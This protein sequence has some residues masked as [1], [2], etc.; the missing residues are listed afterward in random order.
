MSPP[1]DLDWPTVCRTVRQVRGWKQF[2]LA[3]EL[4]ITRQCVSEWECGDHGPQPRFGQRLIALYRG[5]RATLIDRPKGRGSLEDSLPPPIGPG[6]LDVYRTPDGVLCLSYR[7]ANVVV[8]VQNPASARSWAIAWSALRI[9]R[10]CWWEAQVPSSPALVEEVA[11]RVCRPVAIMAAVPVTS[12]P[13][14]VA[15]PG[16]PDN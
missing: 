11:Y 2:E 12:A 10:W 9:A 13:A 7:P 3:R 14:P 8:I 1:S 6:D 4:G 16:C 5:A 15:F